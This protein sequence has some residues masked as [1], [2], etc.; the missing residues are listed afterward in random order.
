M[1]TVALGEVLQ[2]DDTD[3]SG[4]FT[5]QDYS[6]Y[7]PTKHER[8]EEVVEEP[9]VEEAVGIDEDRLYEDQ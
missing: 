8:D 2:T 9:T 1:E 5:D 3:S 6:D 4:R 7:D